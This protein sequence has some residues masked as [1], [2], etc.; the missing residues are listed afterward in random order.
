MLIFVR[1][2]GPGLNETLSLD[3]PTNTTVEDLRNQVRKIHLP[4]QGFLTHVLS[5]SR[6]PR[7]GRSSCSSD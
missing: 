5:A 3:V 7:F 4:F 2:F 1:L 6:S